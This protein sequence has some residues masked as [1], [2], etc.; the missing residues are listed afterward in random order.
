MNVV[1]AKLFLELAANQEEFRVGLRT[2]AR[3]A[4]SLL[5]NEQL[6]KLFSAID[7]TNDGSIEVRGS[8]CPKFDTFSSK[9]RVLV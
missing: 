8:G 1:S 6:Q 4:P 3:V 9:F 7:Y 5:S 2:K